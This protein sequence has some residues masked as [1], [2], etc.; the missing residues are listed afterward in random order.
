[1]KLD[2]LLTALKGSSK[3]GSSLPSFKTAINQIDTGISQLDTAFKNATTVVENGVIKMGPQKMPLNQVTSI[4]KS[5]DI[6]TLMKSLG[7]AYTPPASIVKTFKDGTKIFPESNLQDLASNISVK[8]KAYPELNVNAKTVDDLN[9]LPTSTREKLD[10]VLTN[11]K[12]YA[13]GALI[14][15][16]VVG[17]IAIG[18]NMYQNLVDAANARAGCF[19]TNTI[20]GKTTS[21]K[22]T[23][24]SCQNTGNENPCKTTVSATINLALYLQQLATSTSDPEKAKIEEKYNITLDVDSISSILQGS[25]FEQISGDYDLGEITVPTICMSS[26]PGVIEPSCRCCDPSAEPNTLAYTDVTALADNYTLIC[27][28]PSSVLETLVDVGVGLGKDIFQGI[29]SFFNFQNIVIIIVVIV[30]I[31]VLIAFFSRKK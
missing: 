26:I 3:V 22:I 17:A 21:C 1:M 30:I 5:G 2:G 25:L 31:V 6:R 20:S 16:G 10:K 29:G 18:V 24:R 11:I 19:L 4:V 27:V 7:S 13:K 8:K 9:K 23:N 12:T 14:V 28:P 15:S